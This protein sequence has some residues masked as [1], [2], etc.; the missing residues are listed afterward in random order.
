[1]PRRKQDPAVIAAKR[2]DL[3][4]LREEYQNESDRAAAIVGAAFLD[5]QIKEYIRQFL[6][7]DE[8]FVNDLFA[9]DRPLGAFGARIQIAYAL[10]LLTNDEYHDLKVVQGIRNAFAH[11]LHGLSF[12]D[13]WIKQQC[14]LLKLPQTLLSTDFYKQNPPRDL[15][16]WVIDVIYGSFLVEGAIKESKRCM[17]PA[18]RPW[19][20]QL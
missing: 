14:L 15:F 7:D 13:P 17:V 4:G 11:D 6:I 19:L 16:L 12:N 1:M 2:I 10:G 8:K 9:P 3:R 18:L 5:E 20:K